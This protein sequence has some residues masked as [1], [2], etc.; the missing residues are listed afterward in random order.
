MSG[1]RL[2]Y[3]PEHLVEGLTFDE[4]LARLESLVLGNGRDASRPGLLDEHEQLRRD[5]ADLKAAANRKAIPWY[6]RLFLKRRARR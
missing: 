4:R 5:V 3:E 2:R 6:L 1:R